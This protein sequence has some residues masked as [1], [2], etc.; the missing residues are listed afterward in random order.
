MVHYK[1]IWYNLNVMRQFACLV[2]NPITVNSFAALFSVTPMD[3]RVRYFCDRSYILFKKIDMLMF[4]HF[5][6]FFFLLIFNKGR[7]SSS[8][9]LDTITTKIA[10]RTIVFNKAGL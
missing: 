4:L 9:F 5:T 10:S 6:F 7:L 3:L 8:S 1:R 2:I